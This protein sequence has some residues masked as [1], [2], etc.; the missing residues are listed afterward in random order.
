MSRFPAGL[1][2]TLAVQKCGPSLPL[3]LVNSAPT[4]A[5]PWN[6]LPRQ[7]ASWPDASAADDTTYAPIA[8][9][10]RPA[11]QRAAQPGRRGQAQAHSQAHGS[12]W[13]PDASAHPVLPAG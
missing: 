13:T 4:G 8:A 7:A 6:G 1:L 2:T 11:R 5:V 12:R 9:A 3:E 10:I